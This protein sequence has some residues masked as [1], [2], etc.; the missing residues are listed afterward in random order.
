MDA[1]QAAR[2]LP[3]W[4]PRRD[5]RACVYAL[6]PAGGGASLFAALRRELPAW[7]DLAPVQY[8]GREQR[9]GEPPL[10]SLAELVAALRDLL[11]G[12]HDVPAVLCG[13]SLGGIV[14]Y[15]TARCWP[16]S[17]ARPL[18]GLIVAGSPPPHLPRTQPPLSHLRDDEL[19]QQVAARYQGL[20]PAILQQPELVK[21]I[22]PPLRADLQCWDGYVH[23]AGGPLLNVPLA[24]ICGATDPVVPCEQMQ[25]WRDLT[26][27]A[28]TY[29]TC[30]GGHFFPRTHAR[31]TAAFLADVCAAWLADAV[32]S[33]A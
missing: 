9:W 14:A 13:H 4:T 32:Q 2:W 27:R 18:L 24:A 20:P 30:Q 3:A 16:A 5:A 21:L 1:A 29:R 26:A 11:P 7:L 17:A 19:L 31:E 6:P 12:A 10:E 33:P 22:L 8:P 25:H 23:A 15:E 28:C